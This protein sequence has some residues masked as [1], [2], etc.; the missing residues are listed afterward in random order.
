MAL[1]ARIER[2]HNFRSW[3]QLAEICPGSNLGCY[4]CSSWSARARWSRLQLGELILP[5]AKTQCD[6]NPNG[7]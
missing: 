4:T 7:R 2:L 3:I 6:A 1:A 5:T